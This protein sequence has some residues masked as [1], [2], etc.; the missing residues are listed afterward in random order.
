M[1]RVLL[2]LLGLILLAILAY[3]CFQNKADT[4]RGHLVSST[5]SALSEHNITGVNVSVRG[6]DIEMTDI[7]KL[8]GEVSSLE[9]KAQAET[10]AKEI[11]GVGDVNNQLNVAQKIVAT[12]PVEEKR[13][14][15]VVAKKVSSIDPYTL[16]I[17]RDEKGTVLLEG[18]VD[19]T[20]QRSELITHAQKLFG[21]KNVTDNLKVTAGAPKDW[22]Y[23]SSFALDRL[24]DVDY[25]DMKLSN[26]SYEFTGHLA[27][28]SAKAS[29]LDGIRE[30]MSDPENKYSL[31]RGDYIVTA[32]VE[33]PKI[34]GKKELATPDKKVPSKTKRSVKACQA[35]LDAILANQ[36]ILFDYNKASIKSNSYTILN[37]VLSSMKACHVSLL[38]IAGHT[39][40]QGAAGYNKRLSDLR[41]A[42]VKRYFVKKGFDKKKLKAIG[43]G[44]SKPIASNASKE[45]RAKNRRIEFIVKGVEK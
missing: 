15:P 13:G 10:L 40:A 12:A 20:Q 36:K 6:Q 33:E 8:T 4:I 43:Y 26:Q 45:G 34:L 2:A 9:M 19:D 39:D 23:I 24:K 25:G 16:S 18:Y 35:K 28:P 32:P 29:F 37:N 1:K 17:T 31:Y 22:E 14:V 7:I 3:F 42:S 38:E 44:E 11:E 21:S 27:S 30:V 5:N 41:A